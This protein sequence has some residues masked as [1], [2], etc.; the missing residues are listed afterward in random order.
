MEMIFF[1]L[2]GLVTAITE[3]TRRWIGTWTP[4]QY[5]LAEGKPQTDSDVTCRNPE[6]KRLINANGPEPVLWFQRFFA[7]PGH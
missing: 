3:L 2:W 6:S 4:A 7:E 5:C 1:F